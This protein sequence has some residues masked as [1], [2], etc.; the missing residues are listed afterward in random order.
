MS[1]KTKADFREAFR[2]RESTDPLM[3]WK[4][5]SETLAETGIVDRDTG[6]P[7]DHKRFKWYHSQKRDD[8]M[9]GAEFTKS[10]QEPTKADEPEQVSID[11]V[12]TKEP[13]PIPEPTTAE[14]TK[15]VQVITKLPEWLDAQATKELLSIYQS[16]KLTELLSWYESQKEAPMQTTTPTTGE[17]LILPEHR[18]LIPGK[19]KNTGVFINERL[20]E[21]VKT[22]LK[23]E[24]ER[25]G[26]SLSQLIEVLLWSYAGSPNPDDLDTHVAP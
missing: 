4:Q 12:T 22:K 26:T 11:Q 1:E 25:V 15:G 21:L 13:E 6:E 18:P 23:T 24:Q 20:M 9:K 7:Y 8:I 17:A 3:P 14:V 5:V 2:L 19:R 10:V 16:G